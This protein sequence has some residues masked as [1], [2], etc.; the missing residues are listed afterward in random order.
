[1]KKINNE[2]FVKN[3]QVT[4]SE[5][6]IILKQLINYCIPFIII[7]VANSIYNS[8]DMILVIK[9]LNNIGYQTTDIETISSIFTTWGSKLVS[10][11]TAI[12]TGL[13]VSLIPSIVAAFTKKDMK[14]VNNQFNKTLQVLLYVILPLSIFLSIFAK[15][16]W[17]VFYG[18]SYYGPLIFKYTILLAVFDSAYIMICSALQGLSKTKLIYISCGL[19]LITKTILD[20][21]L[22]YLFHKL[23]L[24][25]F[26]GAILASAIGYILSLSIPLITLALKYKFNYNQTLKSI[27]RLTISIIILTSLCLIIKPTILHFT[28]RIILLF[29]LVLIGILC[30]IIYS[31]IN[32]QILLDLIGERFF[33][34]LIT[35]E[36][37]DSKL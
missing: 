15:P 32:K 9:G 12:A 14:E 21:P 28:N 27:P 29:I 7:N 22:I 1:M 31:F 8:I 20:L 37:N 30:L 6:K 25:A 4:K 2:L 16:I 11:V 19:G 3:A 34:K 35:K 10:I 18:N 26:H 23:G 36:K 33:K 13:V 5:K 17:Q 24:H